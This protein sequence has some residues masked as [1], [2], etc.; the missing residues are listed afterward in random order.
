MARCVVILV[1]LIAAVALLCATQTPGHAQTDWEMFPD[2]V[3]TPTHLPT[4]ED[5]GIVEEGGVIWVGDLHHYLMTYEAMPT[6]GGRYVDRATG[7]ASSPDGIHWYRF[8]GNPVLPVAQSPP[9]RQPIVQGTQLSENSCLLYDPDDHSAPYKM[10]FDTSGSALNPKIWYA[11]SNDAIHWTT[12]VVV[13]Q[14][15]PPGSYDSYQIFQCQVVKVKGT[16]YMYYSARNGPP[17][18]VRGIGVATWDGDPSHPWQHVGT[19]LPQV[20]VSEWDYQAGCPH[21]LYVPPHS[22]LWPADPDGHLLMYYKGLPSSGSPLRVGYAT[23]PPEGQSGFGTNFTRYSGNP[24]LSPTTN[25]AVWPYQEIAATSVILNGDHL[26]MWFGSRLSNAS[27]VAVGRAVSAPGSAVTW[28][29]DPSPVLTNVTP[30]SAFDAGVLHHPSA[31]KCSPIDPASPPGCEWVLYCEGSAARDLSQSSVGLARSP[32]GVNWFKYS[33]NPVVQRQGSEDRIGMPGV[34][35][36]PSDPDGKVWWMYY[37]RRVRP[38]GTD[39]GAS[40]IVRC[41]SADG[42][43]WTWD[44][45]PPLYGAV[46]TVPGTNFMGPDVH[47]VGGTYYMYTSDGNH[48]YLTTSPDGMNWSLPVT[49]VLSRG[50]PGTADEYLVADASVVLDG[51][52]LWHMWYRGSPAVGA[53]SICYSWSP[54]G[55]NGWDANKY[56]GNPVVPGTG[57]VNI[58]PYSATGPTV[59]LDNDI[60]YMWFNGGATLP[61]TLPH[62]GLGY[63]VSAVNAAVI[64]TPANPAG[65][66]VSNPSVGVDVAFSQV[67]TAGQTV[68]TEGSAPSGSA[69]PP[70]YVITGG[71]YFS[72]STTAGYVGEIE[73]TVTYDDTGM[74]LAQEQAQRLMH[75][76]EATAA[77]E[78]ITIRV[79]TGPNHIVGRTAS[80]CMFAQAQ[81][82]AQVIEAGDGQAQP[83]QT[84]TVLVEQQHA[85]TGA[86][87]EFDLAY[88]IGRAG[89]L[90][91]SAVRAGVALPAGWTLDSTLAAHSVHIHASS[92]TNTMAGGEAGPLVEVDFTANP[93]AGGGEGCTLHPQNIVVSDDLGAPLPDVSGAD[94]S[95]TVV[96]APVAPVVASAGPDQAIAVGG[97][98][99]TGGSPSASGGVPPY[100]CA[101]T[102]SPAGFTSSDPNPTVSPVVTTTYTLTVIDNLGQ[103]ATDSMVV[104]VGLVAKAGPDRLIRLGNC[105]VLEGSASGGT[106]PYTYSWTPTG[107]LDIPTIAQ[108][109]CC[110]TAITTYTLRVTDRLSNFAEDTV[111]VYVG[112]VV[113]ANA[114]PDGTI[115]VGSTFQLLGGGG[116]GCGALHYSWS[117]TTGLDDPTLAQPTL[118]PVAPG[119]YTFTLTVTDSVTPTPQSATDTCTVT[120]RYGF[121]GILPPINADGSSIF[122]LGSTVPVKFQLRDANGAFVTTAVVRL[123]TAKI[124]NGIAGTEIEAVSTAAATSGNLFRYDAG[125]N[126]YIFN[127]GTKSL[128]AGT[129]Q[130]RIAADDGAS[131]AC[132]ISLK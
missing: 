47:K 65:E 121:G 88:N 32:D 54:D 113:T 42:Y 120:V 51:A 26:D 6:G 111:T 27:T 109:T 34:I 100:T 39:L 35:Y 119:T 1:I 4:W 107:G 14:T 115:G 36:E 112:P 71:T 60:Y 59:V 30:N 77:W 64:P 40:E 116:G 79:E 127:L 37:F 132:M 81:G 91:L 85:W 70:G 56:S 96:P 66:T 9:G 131:Y 31:V 110:V 106:P 68:I 49:T 52:G 105:T 5:G 24:I 23:C 16:Y 101:W 17:Q 57:N 19:A 114:G 63:A 124:S 92:P 125:A 75:W 95:F 80:L 84:G 74:T 8:A 82:T 89:L 118:T 53:A 86:S 2:P 97:S 21:V 62:P 102:S 55:I 90:T 93:A 33:G 22:T 98:V 78:D 123:Y 25:P 43:T 18:T 50:G 38:D 76:N 73:I 83:G 94:G 29:V 69:D 67:D 41:R 44:T 11:T 61:L 72:V 87:V 48:I 10:W 104:T 20:G 103:L 7:I 129:W 108:P 13:L 117:P 46:L 28:T 128:S 58:F 126:Q 99:A 3:V 130:I 45:G 15:G 12:P 122:K